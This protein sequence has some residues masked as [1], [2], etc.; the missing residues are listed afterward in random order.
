MKKSKNQSNCFQPF[1]SDLHAQGV[2][3]VA[4]IDEAGRGP[5]AGPVVAAAVLFAPGITIHGV[6]DSKTLSGRQRE[7]IYPQIMEQAIAVGIGSVIEKVIDEINILQATYR[8]MQQALIN[9]GINVDHVLV[10]GRR[11]PIL[12]VPQTSIIKGDRLC[13]SIAAASIIAKVTRDREMISYDDQYPQYGFARHK[14]YGTEF[15]R[16][17]IQKYGLCP[18]HRRSFHL[19]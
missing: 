11:N 12:D 10:D 18:I 17:A 13:F 8:A 16:Q 1:E 7:A 19:K 9:L 4:G 15:H 5:L 6:A 14:G 2:L 3:N